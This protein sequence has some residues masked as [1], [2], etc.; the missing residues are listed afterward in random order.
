MAQAAKLLGVHRDQAGRLLHLRGS[1]PR[2]TTRSGPATRENVGG[3]ADAGIRTLFALIRP[4]E[5]DDAWV[6]TVIP[7]ELTHLVFDTAVYNPY[8]FPPRW[9][10]EG[11]AVYES[12]GYGPRATGATSRAPPSDGTLIPLTGPDRAVPDERETVLA[13]RTPRACPRSTS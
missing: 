7:H 4:S 13:S 3:Q 5:I 11:L 1:G 12:E 10:N 8:H 6:E 2:S 9:L